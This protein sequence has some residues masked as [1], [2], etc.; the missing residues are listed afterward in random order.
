MKIIAV[1]ARAFRVI[2][3]GRWYSDPVL[4]R[5]DPRHGYDPGYRYGYLGFRLIL[6]VR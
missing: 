4:A 2:R 5:V 3:G 1:P 6:G